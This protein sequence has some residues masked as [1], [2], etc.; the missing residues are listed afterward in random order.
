MNP[1]QKSS[2]SFKHLTQLYKRPGFRIIRA[3]TGRFADQWDKQTD[4]LTGVDNQFLKS[5]HQSGYSSE[6]VKTGWYTYY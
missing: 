5:G 3:G 2:I 6:L 4:P 1:Q